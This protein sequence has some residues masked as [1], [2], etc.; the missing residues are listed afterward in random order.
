MKLVVPEKPKTEKAQI[1]ILWDI[2]S[3]HIIH[4]LNWQDIKM[5]F[6]LGLTGLILALCAVMIS[7][8][9]NLS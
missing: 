8:I 2:I 1:S 3:N 5:N 4:R 9:A 6:I 7:L